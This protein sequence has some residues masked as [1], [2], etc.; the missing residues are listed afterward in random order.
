LGA[1]NLEGKLFEIDQT[2]GT[3]TEIG[4]GIGY[5]HTTGLAYSINGPVISVD[6]ENSYLPKSYSLKQNYP[7][8]FN[9]STKIEFSLP[10]AAKVQVTIYNILGQQVASLINEQ[11]T[12]GNHSVV[13]NSNSSNGTKLSSGIYMYKLEASGIDGSNFQQTRKMILLK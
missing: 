11:L 10:V 9:P 7:N 8:P 2:N 3:G 13:W 12:A 6:G 5:N 4:T 1:V